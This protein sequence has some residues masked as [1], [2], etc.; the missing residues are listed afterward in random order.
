MIDEVIVS[1][2]GHCTHRALTPREIQ[3]SAR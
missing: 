2:D 3:T 1:S